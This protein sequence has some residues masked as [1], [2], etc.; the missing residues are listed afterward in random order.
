[1]KS[2]NDAR[3]RIRPGVKNDLFMAAS[4]FRVKQFHDFIGKIDYAINEF[5][6]IIGFQTPMIVSRILLRKKEWLMRTTIPVKISDIEMGIS[7]IL[8]TTAINYPSSV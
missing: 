3:A 7:S 4:I 8:T 1:M 2:S 6:H 5:R